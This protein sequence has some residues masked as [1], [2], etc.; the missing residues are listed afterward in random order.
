MN[1]KLY[2]QISPRQYILIIFQTQVGIGVLSLPRDLA[3]T[4]GT[5]GWISIIL[6]WVL[7]I[8]VSLVIVNIMQKNPESTLYELL[9]T[10]FGMWI[11]KSLSILWIV[12]AAFA[13]T[14]VMFSTIHIIKIWI[15]PET[16]N[17][18]LMFL[19]II[20]HYM[21]AKDRVRVIGLFADL[22]LLITFWMPILL[23]IPLKD[24]QWPYQWY[25]LLPIAKDGLIP[26]LTTV[27]STILSFLGFEMAF[28]LYPFLKDKKSAYKGI[29][30]ANSLS[31]ITFLMITV[32]SFIRFAPEEVT[33]YV[34]PTLNLLKLIQFPFLERLEILFLSF[35]L[36]MLFM[37]IIPYLYMAVLGIS[38]LLGKQD[39][40]NPLRIVLS[41]WLIMSFF[42]IPSSSQVT[43]MGKAWGNL[44]LF[45][46]FAF[47]IFLWIYLWII[48]YVRKEQKQ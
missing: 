18:V 24:A 21:I 22:V 39:H 4:A 13:A 14:I 8:L 28:I 17:F 27:K 11:G 5:D 33:E 20:P 25:Y 41:I 34:Y 10:Y 42:F 43:E 46:A 48:H 2:N 7:S 15:L 1:N 3:K 45:F 30:I 29:I 47:P 19:F 40:R 26:I 36:F 9:S 6:G 16:L 38:Q 31:M 23:L 32:I 37:T 35:Y 44:G 12:Y